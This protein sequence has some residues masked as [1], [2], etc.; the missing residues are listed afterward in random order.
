MSNATVNQSGWKTLLS[1]N[2]ILVLAISCFNQFS[3]MAVKTPINQFGNSLGI[4]V[5][6]LGMIATMYQASKMIV[7]PLWG[8]LNDRM[9]RKTAMTIALVIQ[10]AAFLIYAV[11]A[12]VPVYILGRFVEGVS[13]GIVSTSVY[14][15]LGVVVDRKVLGTAMGFYAT[16]PQIVKSLA[17]T[18]S[19]SIYENAGPKYSFLVAAG[20]TACSIILTQFLDFS[21]ASAMDAR[22]AAKA[23][24]NVKGIEKFFTVKSLYFLP[25]L[26]ADGFQNGVLD[27]T[28]VLYAT[29]IGNAGAGAM[30]F[31]VQAFVTIFVAVP[32]GFVQDK[33]G[34]KYSVIIAMA[35]RAAGC[36]LVAFA[37]T[38]TNFIIAGILCGTAKPGSNVIQTENMKLVPKSRFG[39]ANS[40]LLLLCDFTVM[41][42]ASVGGYLVDFAG[43]CKTCFIV[44]AG[45]LIAGAVLYLLEQ[46]KLQKIIDEAAK[47]EEVS[48]EA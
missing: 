37:P 41:I 21:R 15:A 7:R 3:T 5:S 14:S 9:N 47:N 13:F 34:G 31:S 28:I 44:A 17:P 29:A 11:T 42:G 22:R 32:F 46:P 6:V 39:V 8:N 43:G 10:G 48:T 30:F 4:A 27:L 45:V 25:Y 12:S 18:L 23:E 36:L 24:S 1:R 19:M 40:S 26:L 33:L 38:A 35:C 16:F 2:F 20:S